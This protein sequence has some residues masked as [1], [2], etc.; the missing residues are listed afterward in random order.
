[1]LIFRGVYTL[2]NRFFFSIQ[3]TLLL[4]VQAP[5]DPWLGFD[6]IWGTIFFEGTNC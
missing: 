2:T 4:A 5:E 6:E 1:M 3:K